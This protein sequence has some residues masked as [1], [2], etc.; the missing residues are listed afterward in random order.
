MQR[1]LNEP[2]FFRSLFNELKAFFKNLFEGDLKETLRVEFQELKEFFIDDERQKRLDK[3]GKLQRWLVMWF[4]LIRALLVKLSAIRRV[5]LIISLYLLLSG[6]G[7]PNSEAKLIFSMLIVLY[8]LMLELKDKLVARD[9]LEAG[10]K[11]QD[12]L[13]PVSDPHIPNWDVWLF[14]RSANQVGGDLVD[15][16]QISDDHFYL[17]LGDVAGKGLP[18]ALFMAKLQATVRALV[19]DCSDI[20]DLGLRLN[21]IFYRDTIPSS[22]SSLIY[23]EITPASG[24]V[25]ILN[26]GHMPPLKIHQGQI[27]ELSKGGPALGVVDEAAYQA[28]RV[29]LEKGDILFIYSD[30]ITEARNTDGR[31]FGDKRMHQILSA[32]HQLSAKKLGSTLLENV[33]KYIG[34]ARPHDDLSMICLKRV[35]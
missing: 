9:E 1:K 29:H 22:F 7:D 34:Q 35:A 20:R 26:A 21:K 10:R 13:S 17:A 32:N 14:T 2:G 5:F 28:E 6:L 25:K 15:Y 18:A 23:T 16:M 3:M 24:Q 11:I 31:F 12:A 4:W 8:V 19:P 33:E 27:E 30:G